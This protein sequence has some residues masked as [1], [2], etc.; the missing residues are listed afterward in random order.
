MT[1]QASDVTLV[2]HI[3]LHKTASS[4]V[5]NLL[6]ARRY[7]LLRHG[8]LYPFTGTVDSP[9]EATREGAQSGH[10][11]FTRPGDRRALVSELL[12]ELPD[13]I[14]TVLM[15]SENFTVQRRTPTPADYLRDLGAF[16]NVQVVL[17][18]RRQDAWI[19]SYYKQ[20]VDQPGKFER[21]S[22]GDYLADVGPA[23]LDFHARFSP[24]R[25]LVG[26]ENFHVLSYDDLPGGHA[27]FR[28]L[29]QVAGV[30]SALLEQEPLDV[31]EYRSVRAI[32]TLGLRILNSYRIKDRDVRV[33]AARS[34]YAVAPDGDIDLMTENMRAAIRST[35]GPINERIESEWF[36][37]PVP[38]LRFGAP[39]PA[40]A[41]DPPTGDEMVDYLD[42]VL[43][44]CE[45]A[46][47]AASK[48]GRAE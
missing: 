14:S 31:P 18:L 47:A 48:A 42:R 9:S 38:G 24:W 5:Q 2:L 12:N 45:Q 37:E 32:D 39:A 44:V 4:Y 46:R 17:V 23:L 13:A 7:D 41:T 25:D 19:E 43:S 33:R 11:L 26:P 15:S 40:A 30:D 29:V 21:R 6:S 22:F 10:A 8:V 1:S 16:G 35:C 3:G 36:D 20:I 27:I 28:R 34:I